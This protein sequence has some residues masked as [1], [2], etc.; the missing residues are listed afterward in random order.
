[1]RE[2]KRYSNSSRHARQSSTSVPSM[3]G[4]SVHQR[5]ASDALKATRPDRP[6][7]LDAF[8]P[9]SLEPELV[10]R[11]V[12]TP[13]G[14]ARPPPASWASMP[15]K[16]QLAILALSRMVD[17][18]QMASLQSYMIHQLRSFDPALPDSAISHQ[19]GILQGSFNG[20]QIVSALVWGRVADMPSFGRKTVLVIGLAGTAFTCVGVG[21][22]HTF[23]QA[24]VWR[25]LG[26]AVNGT[27]GSARTMVAE[28]VDKRFHSRAFLL[29]PLAFNVANILG[30]SRS[31]HGN[32]P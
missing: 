2:Q 5:H 4:S 26:G 23:W 15:H 21:F 7:R 25:I 12:R 29:L 27:V 13:V 28:T 11:E 14:D 6:E 9:P 1:M 24:A 30:P 19:A 18:W 16:D 20:A 10:Q 17:F 22:A 32:C 31:I 8:P 3:K